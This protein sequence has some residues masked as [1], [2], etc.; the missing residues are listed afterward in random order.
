MNPWTESETAGDTEKFVRGRLRDYHLDE[1]CEVIAATSVE[2]AKTWTRKI[3]LLFIEGDHSFDG[4][5]G[6]FEMF[7]PRLARNALITFHDTAWE[8]YS[9]PEGQQQSEDFKGKLAT[10]GVPKFL[11]ALSAKATAPSR[12]P[13]APG[14][15]SWI[16]TSMDLISALGKMSRPIL[17]LCEVR[18]NLG[19]CPRRSSKRPSQISGLLAGV[20]W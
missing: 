11:D 13:S 9:I 10:M 19:F 20:T 14:P 1:W 16:Q 7:R 2:A 6:D 4:V 18:R 8:H 12:C 5:R 3:D 15:R 17:T